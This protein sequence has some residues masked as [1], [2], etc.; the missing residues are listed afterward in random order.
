[1]ADVRFS[2][3]SDKEVAEAR[4]NYRVPLSTK[5]HTLWSRNIYEQCVEARNNEF[6][7]F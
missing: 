1:M 4:E 2:F 3:V 6:R 5:R 7:D